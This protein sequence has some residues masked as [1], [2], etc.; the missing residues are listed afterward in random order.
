MSTAIADKR[1]RRFVCNHPEGDKV[2][3]LDGLSEAFVGVQDGELEGLHAV[4]SRNM[5]VGTLVKRDKLTKKEAWEF[6]DYNIECLKGTYGPILI[7]TP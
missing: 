1:V 7:N 4:Y 6:L 3:L 2:V 5:I